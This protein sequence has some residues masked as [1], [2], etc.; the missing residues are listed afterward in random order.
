MIAI[1]VSAQ[2]TPS[3]DM[4][5]EWRLLLSV[6]LMHNTATGPTVIDESTP[7]VRPRNSMSIIVINIVLLIFGHNHAKYSANILKIY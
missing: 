1:N 7:T 3:P 5:P 2:A 4:K 6:R